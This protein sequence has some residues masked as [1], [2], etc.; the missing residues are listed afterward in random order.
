MSGSSQNRARIDPSFEF[1]MPWQFSKRIFKADADWHLKNVC[2]VA[3]SSNVLSFN[4][5]CKSSQNEH[6]G[7]VG[8]QET[9]KIMMG[10]QDTSQNF[11][12]FPHG[13][14]NDKHPG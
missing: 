12:E 2:T 7:C 10:V 6:P 5:Q 9:R 8:R 11:A 14:G 3:K 1:A 13:T 4:Q